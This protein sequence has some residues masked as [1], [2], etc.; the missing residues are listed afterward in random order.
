MAA[1]DDDRRARL[2][3][4]KNFADVLGFAGEHGD[5]VTQADKK[6]WS[7]GFSDAMAMLIA[8]G[9]RRRFPGI[10]PS[11][12]GSGTESRSRA[13]RGPK[14]LDVNYSKPDI[15]LG[16]GVSIKSINF[17]EKRF[18]KNYSRNDNELRA[19]ALDYH[20]RQ[21]YAVLVGV[22]F[23]PIESCDDGNP[24]KA[25]EAGA[26][27]FGAAV[28]YFRLRAGRETPRDEPELFEAFF[29]GL[30]DRSDPDTVWFYDVMRPRPPKA[31]RPS[32]EAGEVFGWK[33]FFVHIAGA[34]D[35][36]NNPP[37]EFADS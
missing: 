26:S 35:Q 33:E 24:D 5:V 7:Q 18:T 36:R 16:L 10:L 29:I 3:G 11:E 23:L 9:L 37:F 6:N 22:L 15:G 20:T 12:D 28:K 13:A 19:E 17:P 14:K 27:S 31:R 32:P 21:P 8:R 1:K 4:I 30:Y 34:F 25:G 2:A